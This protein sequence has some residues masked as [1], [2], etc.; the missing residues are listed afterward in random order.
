[1]S[2][3]K[4]KHG[5]EESSASSAKRRRATSNPEQGL[6]ELID[7]ANSLDFFK[8][9]DRVDAMRRN[10]A[11]GR[12]D[13][14][15]AT[16]IQIEPSK[17]KILLYFEG[18]EDCN[19]WKDISSVKLFG[20]RKLKYVHPVKYEETN[21]WKSSS[22]YAAYKLKDSI[23][24]YMK[25]YEYQIP[26]LVRLKLE[27]AAWRDV[28]GLVMEEIKKKNPRQKDKLLTLQNFERFYNVKVILENSDSKQKEG[29]Y[30]GRYVVC[31]KGAKCT[32]SSNCHNSPHVVAFL[33]FSYPGCCTGD[34]HVRS[35]VKC[36]KDQYKGLGADLLCLFAK[37]VNNIIQKNIETISLDAV[38]GWR[39]YAKDDFENLLN[40]YKRLGFVEGRRHGTAY[41]C[42]KGNLTNL[43]PLT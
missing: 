15:P 2:N 10:D 32:P 14:A 24:K 43:C 16:V 7:V 3:R 33:Y 13:W 21:V 36:T 31:E 28:P 5:Q 25:S 1:M 38:S 40:L 4:R 20:T 26:E 39:G 30:E 19:Q 8:I 35:L 17:K 9:G 12:N 23:Q 37:N 41:V 18:F 34:V 29:R 42:M 6:K 22:Y 27:R 11:M